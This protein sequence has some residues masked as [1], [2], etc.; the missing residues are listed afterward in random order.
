MCARAHATQE[1]SVKQRYAA[2]AAGFA[3]G[4][5]AEAA[6]A[7]SAPAAASAPTAS[8]TE[9]DA[10]P[11]DAPI[12]VVVSANKREERLQ[13]VPV[14]VS[15][16]DGAQLARQNVSE[17]TD[18]IRGVPALN[19]AG[20]FG[21][22]SIRGI[23]S[24][25][26]S[27]SAEGS[28]G[29]VVD[30]VA[31]AGSSTSP[32]G[33]FDIARVEV[34]EGPQ[35]TLFGRNSS[36]GLINI[37]T[38]APDPKRLAGAV[39][40]DVGSRGNDMTN[41]MVNMPLADHAALRVSGSFGYQPET[42]KN[43]YD[44]TWNRTRLANG[45]ARLLWELTPDVTANLIADHS[46]TRD[47][48][49]APW[50]IYQSTA[51]SILSTQLAQCGVVVSSS[52]QQ[53][54]VEDG[55]VSTTT[56][57]GYSAQLDARLHGFVLSSITALRRVRTDI[58]ADDVD[59]LQIDLLDQNQ[60]SHARNLSQ[61]FKVVSPTSDLG[62]YVLGLY[63]F[64]GTGDTATSQ[65]GPLLTYL[66]M[67]L[68]V[69]QTLTT[70][71]KSRSY[72]AYGQGNY[73]FTDAFRLN[74]GLRYGRE[75]V[76]AHT[77][78]VLAAGAVAPIA[79]IGPVDGSVSN[80]YVSYRVGAQ[81][82]LSLS[83]MAY[84]S[85]TRGY[86]GPAVND[87]SGGSTSA[88]L[89][90][91][92]EIPHAAE[93]GLKSTFFNGRM[94]ANLAAFYTKVDNFQAQFFDVASAQYIYGNAPSL[95]SRGV[96]LNLMGKPS[97]SLTMNGGLTY[98][99]ARYGAGYTV[100]CY[101]QQTASEGCLPLLNASG[102]AVGTGA[103]AQGHQLVA[104][105]RW[106]ALLSGEY[107][108]PLF[109]RQGFV[110]AD[111]VYTSRVHDDATGDPAVD[112]AGTAIV[113]GRTGLRSADG[114]WSVALFARNLFDTFRPSVRFAA[115]VAAQELDPKAYAQMT[116]SESRRVLGLSLDAHF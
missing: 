99:D 105:P 49:G 66:G 96:S 89:L 82:D 63:Y 113:G 60:F 58:P 22:L 51:G 62:D 67:P 70:T 76:D 38:N 2:L 5:L 10:G 44:D 85:Y 102:S 107:S 54:C 34:L 33:L 69:G 29:V 41:A 74:L 81:Y 73:Y 57:D 109:G 84:V 7:Q 11:A 100:S 112:I 31:L 32:P 95:T 93:L 75:S 88:P 8:K 91:K 71:T 40:L 3:L 48:G 98:T 77:R 4:V 28:V 72:A 78:G 97:S 111:V 18:L 115:P 64:D 25:S 53:G 101:Q 55:N 30:G 56:T 79:G 108:A 6:I 35:G 47:S 65:F 86:K 20:P 116:G 14:A 42:L 9:G 16:V 68:P 15:V 90:V 94:A 24:V 27:R 23:G 80:N 37:V 45:R 104:S 19:V 12:T 17:V 92:P 114:S 83:E 61:E 26:F 13:D 110:Q 52:N 50:A 36:A 1:T 87:Q 21:A 59:N 106:K 46:Q 103:S 43:V 39:H